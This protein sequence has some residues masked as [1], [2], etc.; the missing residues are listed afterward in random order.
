M[1][2]ELF[3]AFNATLL[4]PEPKDPSDVLRLIFDCVRIQIVFY[5]HCKAE[6]LLVE[7]HPLVNHVLIPGG[8]L[9]VMVVKQLDKLYGGK[10]QD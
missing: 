8:D 2:V 7:V 1:K 4:L 5:R 6:P 3:S 9:R 10:G